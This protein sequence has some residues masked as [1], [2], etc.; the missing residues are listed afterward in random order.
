MEVRINRYLSEAGLC[1]RR[2]AD[3]LIEEGKIYIDNQVATMGSKVS[4]GQIVTYMGKV[5][6]K[7]ET[8]V[9]LAFN[10]PVGLVCTAAKEDKNNIIDY[11]NYE[12]RIYPVGRLD[13][14]SQGLILL[15]NDGE[16]MNNILKVS[17]NHEKEYVVTV[18]KTVTDD[19]VK[20]MQEGVPILNTVTRKCKVWKTDDRTF[21][22]IL[23]QGLNR[24]IRRM[25]EY[26]GYKVVK[27]KR[28]RI[29]NI[30]LG[31]LPQG[32]YREIVGSELKELER[33]L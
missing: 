5:I 32:K 9:I 23:M 28:I 8:R 12:K 27:L 30:K 1:S 15:T 3:K 17:N 24:Q 33:R 29:M 22:I 31:N 21:H 7:E 2:A 13:K 16:L 6:T 4:E 14:D 19:F 25:C 26:F 10:K 11:I 20:G 18:N